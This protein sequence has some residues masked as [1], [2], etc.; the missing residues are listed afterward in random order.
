MLAAIN[1]LEDI[2]VKKFSIITAFATENNRIELCVDFQFKCGIKTNLILQKYFLDR[3]QFYILILNTWALRTKTNLWVFLIYNFKFF[4]FFCLFFLFYVKVFWET[5]FSAPSCIFN[6]KNLL[7]N[8]LIPKVS[9]IWMLTVSFFSKIKKNSLLVWLVRLNWWAGQVE[10]ALV[11]YWNIANIL[12]KNSRRWFFKR[13]LLS[14]CELFWS[15]S[16]V[17]HNPVLQETMQVYYQGRL[18]NTTKH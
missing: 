11:N 1:T 4:L 5:K 3:F 6:Q 10:K 14:K 18:I 8:S 12:P 9:K 7:F 13:L 15:H 16:V 17:S 2:T